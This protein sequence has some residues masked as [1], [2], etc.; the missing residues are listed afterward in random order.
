MLLLLLVLVTQPAP[1]PLQGSAALRKVIDDVRASY[2]RNEPPIVVFDLDGALFDNR[3]RTAQILHEYAEQDLRGI[4]PDPAARL[5]ALTTPHISYMLTDTLTNAGV[6]EAAVVN[7]AA[8]FW[9]KRYFSD[10]YLHYD[11][12][13][14]GAIDY[15][16]TLYSN[17]ARI[18]YLSSRDAAR[19]LVGTTK[20]LLDRGCPIGIASTE[21]ILKPTQSTADATFKTQLMTYLRQHGKVMAIFDTQPLNANEYRRQF[22]EAMT[23]LVD[24]LK[25]PN[26]P[27]IDGAV[28]SVPTYN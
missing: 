14:P 9:S 18:V 21:I 8:V 6:N 5:S 26:Q 15:V 17:G 19:Q 22:P 1:P 7:N 4:R 25:A 2:N 24:G 12:P 20:L 28:I 11:Q 13:V 3:P 27:P 16:R 10:N 23:F